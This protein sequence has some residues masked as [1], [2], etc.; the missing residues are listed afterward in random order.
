MKNGSGQT[1]SIWMSAEVPAS[2]PLPTGAH[3]DVCIVGAGIAGLTTAYI[4]RDGKASPSSCST[5]APIGGGMTQLTTAHLTNAIDDR[6]RRNRAA[7]RRAGGAPRGR[8][9]HRGH[10]PHRIDRRTEK[11]RLRFRAVDGYLFC[12]PGES[13]RELLDREN[14][15]R[16]A[17]AGLNGVER[18]ARLPHRDFQDG[19]LHCAF[20]D[21]AS[22]IPL[23]YLA[24]LGQGDRQRRRAHLHAAARRSVEGGN[25]SR[26]RYAREVS[27]VDAPM[28]SSSRP[29]RPSTTWCDPH[30]A[31]AVH[32]LRHRRPRAARAR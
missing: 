25:A 15:G 18:A 21:R 28:P 26:G 19:A 10:R 13:T 32:D 29:I 2:P 1:V 5:T 23:K 6:L 22:F 17:Q 20:P 16:R 31:G 14:A 9:P 11:D 3:A 4:A 30:Q 12:P 8:Q 24:G 7:P 27:L